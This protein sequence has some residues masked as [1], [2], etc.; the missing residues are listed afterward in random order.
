MHELAVVRHVSTRVHDNWDC[1]DGVVVVIVVVDDDVTG[2]AVVVVV[3]GGDDDDNSI[4]DFDCSPLINEGN[5]SFSNTVIVGDEDLRI[6][7][8]LCVDNER[9]RFSNDDDKDKCIE[10]NN[11]ALSFP[12]IFDLFTEDERKRFKRDERNA[13]TWWEGTEENFDDDKVFRPN[14]LS[15]IKLHNWSISETDD[16]NLLVL[17]FFFLASTFLYWSILIFYLHKISIIE[18]KMNIVSD[19]IFI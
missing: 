15:S 19:Y 13:F 3:T 7:E 16:D 9:N 2:M 12:F 10:R 1:I 14:V 11:E 5:D 18:E 17:L 4:D 6:W 8:G